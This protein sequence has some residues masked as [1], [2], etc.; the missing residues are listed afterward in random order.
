MKLMKKSTTLLPLRFNDGTEVPADIFQRILERFWINFGGVTI[1]GEVD[2]HWIDT[3]DQQ[4][5]EDRS[6]K[7]VVIVPDDQLDAAR[8]LVREARVELGQIVM[9]FEV[10]DVDFEYLD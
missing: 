4:H 10:A 3:Q 9:Y 2:G 6:K 1:E 8:E 5:Y 7:V